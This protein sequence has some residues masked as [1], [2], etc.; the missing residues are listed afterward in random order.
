MGWVVKISIYLDARSEGTGTGTLEEH[1]EASN[2]SKCFTLIRRFFT[3]IFSHVGLL[4]LVCGYCILG[5]IA[6]EH[7]EKENELQVEIVETNIKYFQTYQVKKDMAEHRKLLGDKIWNI[8]KMSKV[9]MQ[10]NWT[11]VVSAE[12]KKFEKEIV[13]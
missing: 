5:A 12:M 4:S 2:L 6:F 9:L 1:S 8:T 3:F 11:K 13:F 7:L 10:E